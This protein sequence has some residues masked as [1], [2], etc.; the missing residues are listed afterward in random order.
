MRTAMLSPFAV[1]SLLLI[2]ASTAKAAGRPIQFTPPSSPPFTRM[3][4]TSAPKP[5]SCQPW[6]AYCWDD[7]SI[8]CSKACIYSDYY[9]GII[10]AP[11]N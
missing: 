10:C 1:T 7:A 4:E 2:L 8:C 6:P 5:E 9:Q 3:E 11:E